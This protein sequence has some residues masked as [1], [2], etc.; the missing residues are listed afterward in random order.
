MGPENGPIS[1]VSP[2]SLYLTPST[3]VTLVP[4]SC[5]FSCGGPGMGC[6]RCVLSHLSGSPR[7]ESRPVSPP[8]L[9]PISVPAPSPGLFIQKVSPYLFVSPVFCYEFFGYPSQTDP[10]P[11][12]HPTV[13]F[14]LYDT[15]RNGILDSSVSWGTCMLCKGICVHLSVP[16]V[17]TLPGS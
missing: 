13:T 16:P 7:V 1:S 9:S 8:I 10:G 12:K 5:I 15:D 11:L 6:G 2:D 4:T 3:I 17:T 14:K